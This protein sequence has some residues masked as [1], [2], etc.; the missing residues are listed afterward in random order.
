MA[1]P[2]LIDPLDLAA[3]LG[4]EFSDAQKAKAVL[5]V[6]AASTLVRSHTGRT[7]VDV[8]GDLEEV[9][10]PVHDVVLQV[11]ERVWRI[12][13]GIT[14]E[15]TGP[16]GV[17]YTQGAN[18]LELT[19]SEK[20]MLGPYTDSTGNEIWTLGTTRGDTPDVGDPAGETIWV[21]VI[22]GEP[23]PWISNTPW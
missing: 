5:V 13:P 22:G 3:W 8:D 7:W 10:T 17:Q 21:P 19:P 12:K 1:D 2:S 4:V 16:F 15:T 23:V 9:P 20:K 11:A 6:Q 18:G 14:Q